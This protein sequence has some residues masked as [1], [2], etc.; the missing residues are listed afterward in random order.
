MRLL[1]FIIAFIALG[2]SNAILMPTMAESLTHALQ[3][4][5]HVL[6]LVQALPLE[7]AV[8][9]SARGGREDAKYHHR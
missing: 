9:K 1:G 8:E 5:Q 3:H 2:L 6:A 7:V 4:C